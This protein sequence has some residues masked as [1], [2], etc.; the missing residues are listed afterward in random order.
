MKLPRCLV[1]SLLCASLLLVLGGGARWLE[2]RAQS[3]RDS[4]PENAIGTTV[5]AK[6][7]D[8]A[9]RCLVFSPDGSMLIAGCADGSIVIHDISRGQQGTRQ[10]GHKS[11]VLTMAV[12]PDGSTLAAGHE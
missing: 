8:R 12:S 5:P 4:P 11:A 2:L 7:I 9:I 3:T 6:P 10:A 1:V